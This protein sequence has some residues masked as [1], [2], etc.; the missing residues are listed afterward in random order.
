MPLAV[1]RNCRGHRLIRNDQ[2]LAAAQERI[3]WF[4]RLLSQIRE[5]SS[6]EEC[7]PHGTSCLSPERKRRVDHPSLRLRARTIGRVAHPSL[8]LRARIIGRLILHWRWI[9]GLPS[10]CAFSGELWLRVEQFL[11]RSHGKVQMQRVIFKGERTV[12][13]I[14]RPSP[15]VQGQD[16]QCERT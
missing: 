11:N 12:V 3:T 10:D 2:E 7:S 16:I 9:T 1:M 14:E 4:L 6:P 15:V 5:K 8:T 13:E